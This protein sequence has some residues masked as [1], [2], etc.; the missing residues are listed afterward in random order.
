MTI[1]TYKIPTYIKEDSKGEKTIS[2]RGI[3]LVKDAFIYNDNSFNVVITMETSEEKHKK[4]LNY[5]TSRQPIE[6]ELNN[7]RTLVLKE[8]LL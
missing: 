8:G 1:R 6:A 2:Y 4:L 5:G 7:Y 3:E